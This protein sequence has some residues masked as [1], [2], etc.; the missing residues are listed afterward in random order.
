VKSPYDESIVTDS[1]PNASKSLEG[2]DWARVSS[3]FAHQN[4]PVCW[5]KTVTPETAAETA[6]YGYGVVG[7]P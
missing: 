7:A 4:C 5:P 3:P 2:C 6:R 1:A